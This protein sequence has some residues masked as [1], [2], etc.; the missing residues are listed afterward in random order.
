MKYLYC[1]GYETP[2]Q[3]ANNRQY[4]WDDEDSHAVWIDAASKEEAMATGQRYSRSFI[5]R[6]YA[7]RGQPLPFIL[8]EDTYACWIEENPTD[9]WPP[10]TLSA[11]DCISP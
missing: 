8:T 10:E 2:E 5:E 9:R 7:E 6:L 1:F 3:Y 11:L 4:G